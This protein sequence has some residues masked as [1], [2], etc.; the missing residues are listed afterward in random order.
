MAIGSRV[1]GDFKSASNLFAKVNGGWKKAQFGYIK[2]GGNWKQ[3][4]AA[5]LVDEFGRAN[6]Q[7]GLGTAVS[8]QAWS[9]LRSQWQILNNAANTLGTK[10]DYPLATV[11]TGFSDFTLEANELSPGA[12]VAFRVSDANNWWAVFPY[13]TQTSTTFTFCARSRTESYCIQDAGAGYFENVC[14]GTEVDRGDFYTDDCCTSD[15]RTT[16][17]RVGTECEPDS[18]ELVCTTRNVCDNVCIKWC[19]NF[20]GQFCCDRDTVCRDQTTCRWVTTPGG[21]FPVYEEVTEFVCTSTCEVYI[22]DI[23]CEPNGYTLVEPRVCIQSGTREVCVE[24]GTGVNVN[25]FYNIRVIR[26][27]NGVV[28]VVADVPVTERWNAVRVSANL[29]TLNITAYKD[30]LYTQTV[31]TYQNLNFSQFGTSYGVLGAP[32]Q[33]EDGRTIGAIT[34]KPLG[35]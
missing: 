17:I 15:E 10:T 25:N 34:V 14:F 21:C 1:S 6:T 13:Y 33:F 5:E 9:V 31:G 23:Q 28:S 20:S 32:S 18:R 11:D 7:S 29:G 35:Q 27:V 8:G 4:W 26:M 2:V 12:G 16:L 19:S 30:S 22:P 24:T 3:F